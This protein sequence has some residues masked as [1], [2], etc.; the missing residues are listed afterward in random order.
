MKFKRD[1]SSC[2]L[3]ATERRRLDLVRWSRYLRHSDSNC[4]KLHVL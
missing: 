1:S 2:V 4:Q 3:T